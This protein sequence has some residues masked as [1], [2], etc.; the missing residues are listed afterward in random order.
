MAGLPVSSIQVDELQAQFAEGQMINYNNFCTAVEEVFTISGLENKPTFEVKCALENAKEHEYGQ[1][2]TEAEQKLYDLAILRVQ[3]IVKTQGVVVKYAF[4]PFDKTNHGYVTASRFRRAIYNTFDQSDLSLEDVDVLVKVY[5][6]AVGDVNYKAFHEDTSDEKRSSEEKEEDSWTESKRNANRASSSIDNTTLQKKV[7]NILTTRRIRLKMFFEDNDKMRR[8]YCTQGEFMRC[9]YAAFGSQLTFAESE[10]LCK[11]YQRGEFVYYSEFVEWGESV[12][13][14]KGL[15]KM[16]LASV[17]TEASRLAAQGYGSYDPNLTESEVEKISVALAELQSLVQQKRIDLMDLF[18]DFDRSN[19][20]SVTLH[21]FNRVMK[22]RGLSHVY[23]PLVARRYMLIEGGA[24][25]V[26]YRAF[27]NDLMDGLAEDGSVKIAMP[28]IEVVESK[29][30]AST[31]SKKVTSKE[32]CLYRI[33]NYVMRRRIRVRDFFLDYDKLRHGT[34]STFNFR[35]AIDKILQGSKIDQ[36]MLT[37]LIESYSKNGA[38]AYPRFCEDVENTEVIRGLETTPSLDVFS[39][40]NK[41]QDEGKVNDAKSLAEEDDEIFAKVLHMMQGIVDTRGML[42]KPFFLN[43]DK[44]NNGHLT[45]SKFIRSMKMAFEG[46]NFGVDTL[47]TKAYNII[48]DKYTNKYRDE[49]NYG[50][51]LQDVDVSFQRESKFQDDD[52]GQGT[53]TRASASSKASAGEVI[54]RLQECN[55]SHRIDFASFFQV[56]DRLRRGKISW[57]KFC[58]ALDLTLGARLHLN[59]AEMDTLCEKYNID[60]EFVNYKRFLMDVNMDDG[61]VLERNPLKNVTKVNHRV[62]SEY[63][64]KEVDPKVLDDILHRL[65]MKVRERRNNVKPLF[66]PYDPRNFGLVTQTQFQSILK[67]LGILPDKRSERD[68]ILAA[69]TKPKTKFVHY[70][71]FCRRVDPPAT[72]M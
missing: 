13:T 68:V 71:L 46:F 48:A 11:L 69:F 6:D 40:T 15:E 18:K 53:Q 16:P 38:V 8:G 72:E 9:L 35:Q 49:V 1:K 10:S 44:H 45:R 52:D 22:I 20:D 67:T 2:L 51:F 54:A 63:D 58:S 60:G 31:S 42:L 33:R 24:K 32:E 29:L 7:L 70:K 65:S 43:F 61:N 25:L 41:F 57:A 64:N 28:D 12:F 36:G 5:G 17:E 27:N 23:L 39:L 4:K 14:K 47:N 21:Q 66:T 19:R 30:N 59:K 55:D 34:L 37:N 50:S 62:F 56:H 26:N 3:N